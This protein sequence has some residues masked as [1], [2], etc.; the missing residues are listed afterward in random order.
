MFIFCWIHSSTL[1][2]L[3]AYFFV[4]PYLAGIYCQDHCSLG[5]IVMSTAK[6][7]Y[8]VCKCPFLLSKLSKWKLG[9]PNS[10]YRMNVPILVY[11]A[12]SKTQFYCIPCLMMEDI[13]QFI[14]YINRTNNFCFLRWISEIVIRI[15]QKPLRYK[16]R[17]FIT[18]AFMLFWNF[19]NL[20]ILT[21]IIQ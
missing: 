4:L 13:L 18:T 11:R 5:K 9:R 17:I 7:K 2:A 20:S 16:L 19:K 3:S 21:F 15:C 1:L 10:L 6:V 14:S 12:W 8:W